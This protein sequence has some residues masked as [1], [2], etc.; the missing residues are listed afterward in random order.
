M[1]P[2][3]AQNRINQLTERIEKYKKEIEH[4]RKT[5][6]NIPSKKLKTQTE[7]VVLNEHDS[8]KGFFLI[9]NTDDYYVNRIGDI[10]NHRGRKLK[11]SSD[12]GYLW[13]AVKLISGERYSLRAHRA[14]AITFLP[15]PKDLPF[16]NH[17]NGIKNDNRVENLEWCT[18]SEN[19]RHS[20]NV[21]GN[22]NKPRL[23]H[24]GKTVNQIR[25]ETGLTY[26]GVYGR[27]FRPRLDTS[28]R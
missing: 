13:V 17:K 19:A 18:P 22:G 20:V 9:P 2:S 23:V 6:D 28:P 8:F 12:R 27:Y 25:E 14:V 4:I 15:N 5:L 10:I 11:Q 21:L 1:I 16:V 3:I 26:A 7:N 24:E